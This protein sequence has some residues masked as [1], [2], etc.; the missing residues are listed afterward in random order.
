MTLDEVSKQLGLSYNTVRKYVSLGLIKTTRM[1]KSYRVSDE[2]VKRILKEGISLNS[3]KGGVR[4]ND[5]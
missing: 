2:E 5:T 3:N 1:G 4:Q